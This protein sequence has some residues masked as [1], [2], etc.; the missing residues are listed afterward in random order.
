MEIDFF[1]VEPD[2]VIENRPSISE[3][4]LENG[5]NDKANKNSYP[6]RAYS[7]KKE[8][9]LSVY[10]RTAHADIEYVCRTFVPGFKVY[11]HTP[12]DV[13]KSSDASIRIPLDEETKIS[14]KPEMITTAEG[15]RKYE[16]IVRQCYFD[17]ERK[18]RFFKFY[19]KSNCE[20]ECI[21]NYTAQECG[22]IKFS[23]PSIEWFKIEF[24]EALKKFKFL[25]G[26]K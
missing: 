11:F 15:L 24:V 8:K 5:Y 20:S 14:I 9:G 6:I 4:S 23:M 17:S 18:L 3:W 22:C 25:Y 13:L 26:S 12:G 7:S 2:T 1:S 21:A 19:S 10:L 16:P